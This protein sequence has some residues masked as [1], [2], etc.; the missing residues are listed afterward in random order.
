MSYQLHSCTRSCVFFQSLTQ[1]LHE[2]CYCYVFHVSQMVLLIIH[3]KIFLWKKFAFSYCLQYE[4]LAL[5][6]LV[7]I[8]SKNILHKNLLFFW[9][10]GAS[11]IKDQV[12]NIFKLLINYF[13][14]FSS[15][16]IFFIFYFRNT[17]PKVFCSCWPYIPKELYLKI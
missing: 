15:I 14:S 7:L 17:C 4:Q 8:G 16:P 10:K 9:K 1:I 3:A 6:V 2:M 5:V 12:W 11:I 13:I